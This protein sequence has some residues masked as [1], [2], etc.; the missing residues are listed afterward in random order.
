M[1][2]SAGSLDRFDASVVELL[3]LERREVFD[4][5][6]DAFGVEP[7]HPGGG[8]RLDLIDVAPTSLVGDEFGLAEP[9]LRLREGP[10]VRN[11]PVA[12]KK[13]CAAGSGRE[14]I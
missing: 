5:A 1:L 10:P 8:C 2:V 11:V 12:R 6:V 14:G 7:E 4:S 3:D 13:S 9:D